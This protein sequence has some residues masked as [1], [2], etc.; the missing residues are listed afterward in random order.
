[1]PTD[2]GPETQEQQVL[3]IVADEQAIEDLCATNCSWC[4]GDIAEGDVV[5]LW[6]EPHGKMVSIN[7]FDKEECV[8]ARISAY[9]DH[10]RKDIILVWKAMPGAES[11][12]Q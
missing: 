2:L 10:V 1:M 8:Q 9:A 3:A 6:G 5:Y 4:D 11:A 7:T 12:V